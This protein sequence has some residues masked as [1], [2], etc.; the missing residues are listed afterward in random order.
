MTGKVKLLSICLL[1]SYTFLGCTKKEQ[2]V[3]VHPTIIVPDDSITVPENKVDKNALLTLVNGLR[4]RGC[5]CGDTKMPPVNAL[6][7]SGTLEKAAWLHSNDMKV[8]NYFEHN[9][10][11][12]TNPGARLVAAGY[13][14][15]AY[16]E[17]IAKGNMDEQAVILGWLSSPSHCKN[18]MNADYYEVGIGNEGQYWTM[19]LGSRVAEK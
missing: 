6:K 14:W 1:I 2:L 12:G 5:N 16:G 4:S 13:K 17:N 10:Q 18:M 11:N 7:W 8:N 3:A 15:Y 19:D 9:S